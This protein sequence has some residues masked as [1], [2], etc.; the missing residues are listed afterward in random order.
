MNDIKSFSLNN[1][2]IFIR[3]KERPTREKFIS[4]FIYKE[5][6]FISD[7]RKEIKLKFNID[8]YDSRIKEFIDK[9]KY[10]LDNSID[11]IYLSKDVY[12]KE[13]D[14]FDILQYID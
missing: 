5:K 11:C 8:L 10:F 3:M 2:T 14:D 6:T 4:S 13:L 7:I 12:E 1:N 9:K